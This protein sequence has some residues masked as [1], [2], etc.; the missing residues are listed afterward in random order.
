MNFLD[1]YFDITNKEF[2]YEHSRNNNILLLKEDDSFIKVEFTN[3]GQSIT[4]ITHSEEDW[5]FHLDDK[6]IIDEI[7]STIKDNF[8]QENWLFILIQVIFDLTYIKDYP[9]I[10]KFIKDHIYNSKLR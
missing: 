9:N 6:I 4:I 1:L 10:K 3:D 8:L 7:Y 2:N 5:L